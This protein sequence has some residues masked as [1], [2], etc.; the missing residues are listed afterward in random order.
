MPEISSHYPARRIAEPLLTQK[1]SDGTLHLAPALSPDGK[2]IAYFGEGNDFFIDLY[3]ADAETG[4]TIRR[5]VK[6]TTSSNYESLRFIYSSGSF[7][8]DGRYF[9]I[10]VKHKDRDDLV[11]FDIK[12]GKEAARL[13]IPLNGINNPTW[14]PDGSQ[15]AFTGYDG[16]LADLF[17]I[18]RD[19]SNLRR[20]TTDKYADL[21][22]Q[23]SPDGKTLA[24]ATDRGPNTN[25]QTLS[26]GNSRIALYHLESGQI[27]MLDHMEYGRNMNP[28]WSPDGR[29]LAFVSDRT[30]I[31]NVFLYDF[32]DKQVS[33]LTDVY[34]GVSGITPISP[35]LSW[36]K[37]TDRLAF[38]YYDDGSWDVYAIDNPRSLRGRAYTDK[39][40]PQLTYAQTR[41]RFD[42][43]GLQ[44]DTGR[45][46]PAAPADTSAATA[47]SSSIYRAPSGLR[48]SGAQPAETTKVSAPVS[49][50]Q[51]LDSN[52]LA[53][54]DTAEFSVTP[55]RGAFHARLRRPPPPS[56]TNGTTLGGDSSA[57]P[58]SRCR[59]CSATAP[60]SFRPR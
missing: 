6:S 8:P 3:L 18:N 14:S 26:T 5:L 54:P 52:S 47:P 33:Q 16:G 45:V 32:G 55:Y 41:P 11:L 12:K 38:A 59:T 57:A 23:W 1:R 34:T 43:A 29:S 2:Y 27:E 35:A 17:I 46:T 39:P 22:P 44:N 49:V 10:A 4:K 31:E 60:W 9:A 37:E 21:L 42:L 50:K 36:A 30:G 19:G 20:L 53:L 7:S 40:V 58:R 25:F 13:A 56:A 28:V 51:L 48:Q 24:F 15:L